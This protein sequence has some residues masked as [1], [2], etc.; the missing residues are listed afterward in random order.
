MRGAPYSLFQLGVLVT[1]LCLHACP[2]QGLVD[3]Y[4]GL[5]QVAKQ[6]AGMEKS[7]RVFARDNIVCV[8]KCQSTAQTGNEAGQLIRRDDCINQCTQEGSDGNPTSSKAGFAIEDDFVFG[9]DGN[10]TLI[11]PSS[12]TVTLYNKTSQP[13]SSPTPEE[14]NLGHAMAYSLPTGL[15]GVLS[16]AWALL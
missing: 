16:V 2:N 8:K 3:Q 14:E 15:L 13:T 7:G 4:S 9:E 11:D 1:L 12:A 10:T 5:N 6:A